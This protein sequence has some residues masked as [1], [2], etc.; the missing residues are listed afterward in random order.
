MGIK[1]G[2]IVE[3]CGRKYRVLSCLG[4]SNKRFHLFRD[5]GSVWSHESD[6]KLVE[7]VQLPYLQIGDRVIVHD[8]APCEKAP[9]GVWIYEMNDR[10]GKTFEVKKCINHSEYGPIVLLDG[11]WFRTYH[12]E[13][14]SDFDIVQKGVTE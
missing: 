9:N 7:S 13:K 4:N 14:V 10:I 8:V 11:L 3:Y 5:S 6:V 2:D 12:L 1:V